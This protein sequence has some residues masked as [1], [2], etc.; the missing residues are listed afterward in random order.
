MINPLHNK[1]GL[2]ARLLVFIIQQLLFS[3]KVFCLE[4]VYNIKIR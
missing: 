2:A 4:I 1:P 3:Y